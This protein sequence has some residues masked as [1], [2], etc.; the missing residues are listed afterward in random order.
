[1]AKF[2]LLI[3]VSEYQSGLN[4]LPAAV[5]DIVAM[6]RVLLHPEMGGFDEVQ[7]LA[8]PCRQQ[9]ASEI[10]LLFSERCSKDDLVLLYFSGHGIK[11]DQ[12]RLYFASIDTEKYKNGNLKQTSAVSAN[13]I[14]DLM[15]NSRCK[16]Q[17]IILDSCFSGAFDPALIS[18]DDGSVDLQNQLGAQGR[19]VLASSSSM[20]Y[21]FEQKGEE[22][23]I[24]TRYLIEG[25]ETGVGDAN[26]DGAIS[27]HELHEY[28]ASKVQETAPK[29]TPKII[30]MKDKGFEIVLAHAQVTDPKLVYRKEVLYYADVGKISR[31]GRSILNEKKQTLELT[32]KEAAE[33]E[34]DV[35]RPYRT[36]LKNLQKYKKVLID[37]LENECPLSGETQKQMDRYQEILGLRSEDISPI[38]ED[39]EKL[40][41]QKLNTHHGN[42][43]SC[44][45]TNGLSS[46]PNYFFAYQ[47]DKGNKFS[48]N[49]TEKITLENIF[50]PGGEFMMGSYNKDFADE[51]PLHKVK[52]P[53]FYISKFPITQEQWSVLAST[54]E[55]LSEALT[56]FKG[57]KRP[58]EC[59][60]WHE[61]T[62]FCLELSQ[63]CGNEFRL[64]TEA[65]WEYACRAGSKKKFYWGD[66]IS[67]SNCNHGFHYDGTTPVSQFPPNQ[68]GLHDLHGNVWE[69]C[70]DI[71]HDNYDAA[72]DD[73]SSWED[74][75]ENSNPSLRILRGGSWD[76]SPNLCRSANR[77][78]LQA[79]AKNN[80]IGF[81]IVCSNPISS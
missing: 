64:P 39:A 70:L 51:H 18:K 38:W 7:L 40:A 35:L 8:N 4:P 27:I 45:D 58:V 78:K 48:I 57:N 20:E 23:S 21:S 46:R 52:I 77:G 5:K 1:M 75:N 81:R 47:V 80:G 32:D 13:T 67:I 12:G 10:D 76:D 31:V 22:L 55:T 49:L 65:E 44:K 37:E 74:E 59:I 25:I 6:Q 11:D 26:E 2:A 15:R 41:V 17:V 60:N 71:W 50:I 54:S 19:V 62:Q 28:A 42:L 69:W 3:G 61:A 29:M 9:M 72:P 16:R 33:I 56:F 14:H 53:S 43:I 68:F 36:R 66:N 24:Y 63:K 79:S 73:G 34:D 30:V